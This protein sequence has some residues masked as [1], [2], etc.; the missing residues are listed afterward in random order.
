MGNNSVL[1]P[2]FNINIDFSIKLDKICYFPGEKICGAFNLMGKEGLL[3]TQLKEP[4]AIIQ[5]VQ[6][7]IIYDSLK[8]ETTPKEDE[9]IIY[10]ENLLFSTYHDANLLTGINI[11][12]S[13]ILINSAYPTC[14]L[15][16]HNNRGFIK[17]YL[18]AEFQNLKVKRVIGIVIKNNQNFTLI[19]KLLQNPFK[20]SEQK[21]KSIFLS[22]KGN[23]TININLPKNSFY[24]D[25]AIPFEII[26]DCKSLKLKINN[27][28]IGLLRKKKINNNDNLKQTIIN[29]KE[30]FLLKN[31]TLNKNLN[32][33][34]IQGV[35]NFPKKSKLDFY[36][37]PPYVYQ[38]I[39]K[40]AKNFPR[41]SSD[42]PK[43]TIVHFDQIYWIAPS[44]VGGLLSVEY[45]IEIKLMFNS[46]FSHED[47]ISFPIDFCSR[48]EESKIEQKEIFNAIEQ[49]NSNDYLNSIYN[50]ND[51]NQINE[52]YS[53]YDKPQKI[54]P[55]KNKKKII[56]ANE[57]N[58][59][60]SIP[61]CG[62]YIN[63]NYRDS[64][65]PLPAFNNNSNH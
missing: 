42:N 16:F 50:S 13:I 57:N 60:N 32:E 11:P 19:N 56:I 48:K 23:Y 45:F 58:N 30:L 28:K 33:H 8:T 59:I 64:D 1:E 65:A 51:Y 14:S 22:K 63:V 36:I 31:I 25:E 37:Y 52:F 41:Y 15:R 38:L 39:E 4:K 61:Q 12:F 62:E 3:E 5:I 20:F 44:C 55:D 26:L 40:D 34:V 10:E 7:Q 6:K 18:V 35:L 27:I 49:A 24:Y 46:S 54:K 53:Q 17:H 43:E 29:E 2:K 21:S 47:T 9:K